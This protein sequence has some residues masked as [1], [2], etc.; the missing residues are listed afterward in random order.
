[1][2][3]L[4]NK[5]IRIYIIKNVHIYILGLCIFDLFSPKILISGKDELLYKNKEASNFLDYF[6]KSPRTNQKNY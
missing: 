2:Y 3:E 5:K 6:K 4:S 1:M